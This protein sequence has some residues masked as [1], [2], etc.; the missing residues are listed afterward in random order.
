MTT[1]Q[2][3]LFAQQQHHMCILHSSS[4]SINEAFGHFKN[5]YNR[6]SDIRLVRT[7]HYFFSIFHLSS[8]NVCVHWL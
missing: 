4:D 6:S 8:Q 3:L 2:D 1:A 5:G 7:L